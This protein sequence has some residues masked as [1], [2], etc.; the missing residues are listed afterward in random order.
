MPEKQL[1]SRLRKEIIKRGGKAYKFVSPGTKGIP[2][3]AIYLP[4]GRHYL[5]ETKYGRNGL[6]V[7]QQARLRELAAIGTKVWVIGDETALKE[8]LSFIDN[9]I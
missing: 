7:H 8:F 2:D 6:S 4:G 9:E 1:E 5:V 3:R